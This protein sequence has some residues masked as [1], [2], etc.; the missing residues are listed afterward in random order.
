MV[1]AN[2]IEAIKGVKKGGKHKR[3]LQVLHIANR[4]LTIREIK[5][6]GKFDDMN[7]VRPRVNELMTEEY[8]IRIVE[9]GNVKDATTGK[10][11]MR[12]RLA[13][14]GERTQPRFNF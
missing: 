9:A 1:H 14:P 11:V 7:E 3:I 13:L 5:I 2:S 10:M 6:L 4:P 12:V 8:G